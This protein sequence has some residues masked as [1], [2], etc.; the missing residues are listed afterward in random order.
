[1]YLHKGPSVSIA[2]GTKWYDF[3]S[4]RN[5]SDFLTAAV[6]VAPAAKMPDF[7]RYAPPNVSTTVTSQVT[8]RPDNRDTKA[9]IYFIYFPLSSPQKLF[10]T[11]TPWA[12]CYCWPQSPNRQ[13]KTERHIWSRWAPDRHCGDDVI[14]CQKMTTY[15][16]QSLVSVIWILKRLI[17]VI[18]V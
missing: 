9:F 11:N 6:S 1:M 14:S 16:V 17:L 18:S 10:P 3:S 13:L 8:Q 7:W 5:F 4:D 12:F 15:W 2:T